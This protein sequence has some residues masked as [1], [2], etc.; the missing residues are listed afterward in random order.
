MKLKVIFL[1]LALMLMGQITLAKAWRGIFPLKST[2]ADV[3][4]RFGKPNEWGNYEFK[5][6]RVSFDYGDGP[7]K[8]LYLS[9]GQDNCKC[10]A[11]ES[12]VMRIFVEPKVSQKFSALKLDL[13]EFRRT[14]IS[15]FPHTFEYSNRTEGITYTVDEQED[16]IKHITYYPSTVDCQE[17]IRTRAPRNRNVWRGLRPLH[18]K[19]KDL[20][21]LFGSPKRGWETSATY[22]TDHESVVAEY[23]DGSCD[24][25]RPDWNVAKGTLI[26]LV[27]NPNPSFVLQELHLDHGRYKRHEIFP[28]PEIDNPPKV[29]NYIDSRNGIVIRTQSSRGGGGE[30][31]V[32]SITYQPS[33][34]DEHLRCP[35]G[36]KTA[37][38]KP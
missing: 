37:G 6:E 29:W 26:E 34:K 23:S 14:P 38:N 8:G 33:A 1:T 28:Y 5:E 25:S 35:K 12:A 7:C 3:E 27:V 17:I 16:E 10:L 31:L 36:G 18:S 20:D 19:R 32:V 21:T 2:R 30:E 13:K 9:L 22:E 11:L 24:A 15:P 4:R